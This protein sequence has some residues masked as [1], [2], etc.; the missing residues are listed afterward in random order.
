MITMNKLKAALL[1]RFDLTADGFRRKF[2]DSK[3]DREETAA[4]LWLDSR[5]NRDE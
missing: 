2:Y 5:S 1:R 3:R 4:E